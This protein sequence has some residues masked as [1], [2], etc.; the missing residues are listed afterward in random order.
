MRRNPE[1]AREAVGPLSS[2][3]QRNGACRCDDKRVFRQLECRWLCRSGLFARQLKLPGRALLPRGACAEGEFCESCLGETFCLWRRS[4]LGRVC[5]REA[6]GKAVAT[7][8]SPRINCNIVCEVEYGTA[9]PPEPRSISTIIDARQAQALS[10]SVLDSH[11]EGKDNAEM[12]RPLRVGEKLRDSLTDAFGLVDWQD[13]VELARGH[14]P[15][16]D[17]RSVRRTATGGNRN[18]DWPE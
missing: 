13:A 10:R 12:V 18:S 7:K 8:E 16:P 1:A 4:V 14:G 2:L 3:R 5:S 15:L 11:G 6:C 9:I 17:T